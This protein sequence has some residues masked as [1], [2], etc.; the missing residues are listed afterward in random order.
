[1]RS[2]TAKVLLLASFTIGSAMRAQDS[3]TTLAGQALTA[4]GTNGVGTNALFFDPAGMVSD[5]AGNLYIADSRNHVIR[6]LATNGAVSTFAGQI[7]AAGSNNGST[8]ARFNVPSGIAI[9]ADGNFFVTDTGNHILRKIT[10]AGT[11]S[12]I[13]GLAGQSG[14]TDGTGA[15]ARFNSPLGIAVSSNGTIY[16]ADCGNHLIRTISTGG[17]VTTLADTPETWGTNDG[18]GNAARFNG[19]LGLALDNEHNLFVS[20][21]KKNLICLFLLKMMLP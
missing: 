16:V 12:T 18:V 21:S 8:Q 10:P 14:F 13:A 20:D 6:K 15:T 5:S 2:W 7:G 17:A 1:M 4:G 3:V 9:D 19:P 11:V